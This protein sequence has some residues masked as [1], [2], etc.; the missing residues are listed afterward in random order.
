MSAPIRVLAAVIGRDGRYLLGLRPA[1]KRHAGCWEFPGGKVEAGESDRD[2]MARELRE[3]LGVDL[4]RLGPEL[5]AR[6]DG[7]SPFE[8][9]FVRVD[10]AGDPQALEHE[11][12]A[13]VAPSQ[14]GEYRLAESDQWCAS[15]LRD[16]A[17]AGAAGPRKSRR[18]A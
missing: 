17:P 7:S 5:G 4:Q 1:G 14:F 2:A 9:V 13:W 15:Q 11:A 3:E 8:I 18:K 16:Y 12:L 6:R 10:I